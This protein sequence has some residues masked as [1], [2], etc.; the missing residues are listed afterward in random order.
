M[1]SSKFIKLLAALLCVIMAFVSCSGDTANA[2]GANP[3]AIKPLSDS[4][5]LLEDVSAGATVYKS[6]S[7]LVDINYKSPEYFKEALKL[8]GELVNSDEESFVFVMRTSKIGADNLAKEVYSVYSILNGECILT[9]ENTYDYTKAEKDSEVNVSVISEDGFIVPFSVI[10]VEKTTRTLLTAEEMEGN[11]RFDKA[12]LNYKVETSYE[13]YDM[14]GKLFDTSNTYKTVEI[15]TNMSSYV[16]PFKVVIGEATHYFNFKS[17]YVRTEN[18]NDAGIGAYIAERGNNGYKYSYDYGLMQIFDTITGKILAQYDIGTPDVY[19][20]LEDGTIFVQNRILVE[21]DGADYDYADIDDYTYRLTKYNLETYLI[22]A[23][24]GEKTEL[25]FD[26][27]VESISAISGFREVEDVLAMVTPYEVVYKDTVINFAAASKIVDKQ[28]SDSVQIFFDN[29]LNINYESSGE[30]FANKPLLGVG[31]TVLSNGSI[32]YSTIE[33]YKIIVGKDGKET[34]LPDSAE[35]FDPV[36]ITE[37]KVY[38]LDLNV[39]ISDRDGHYG[40]DYGYNYNKYT[41][42]AEYEKKVI[43]YVCSVGDFTIFSSFERYVEDYDD[44]DE[45]IYAFE[46]RYYRVHK[47]NGHYVIDTLSSV[48]EIVDSDKDYIIVENQDGK[49]VL[50]NSKYEHV[51]TSESD[52]YVFSYGEQYWF[53]TYSNYEGKDLVFKLN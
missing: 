44:D 35:V 38:D 43:E 13:F 20:I 48:E 53:S 8:E 2:G 26:Y 21:D 30:D 52:I 46:T 25:D 17:E 3:D 45:P 33:G 7:D 24:T 47:S 4:T 5:P 34:L 14:A 23:E 19:A 37:D 16:T 22:N 32:L 36:I 9:V 27:I 31:G 40:Y 51:F 39:I 41:D 1:K 10:A 6:L 15:E 49:Y 18:E 50:Y 42:D 28:L 11:F 29:S 12:D